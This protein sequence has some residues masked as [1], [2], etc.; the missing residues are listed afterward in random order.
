MNVNKS[1]YYLPFFFFLLPVF[2]WSQK[3]YTPASNRK[4]AAANERICNISFE[5]INLSD[6]KKLDDEVMDYLYQNIKNLQHPS[7]SI[8]QIH[9][10]ESPAGLH[11]TYTQLINDVAVYNSQIKVNLDKQA[12]I[13]SLFDNSYPVS[14][15][16]ATL[17]Y[18]DS[19]AVLKYITNNFDS[20]VRCKFE[21]NLFNDNEQFI[22][23]VRLESFQPNTYNYY[24]TLLDTHGNVLY[25]KDLNS[26]YSP[27]DSL[28][29]AKVFRPDPIT[30]AQVTYGNP[31]GFKDYNDSDVVELNKQRIKVNLTVNFSNGV[32]YLISPFVMVTELS[33]P[34]TAPAITTVPNFDFTRG[35][36]QFEEV[37]AY[38]HLN[39][40]R[41][42]VKSLGFTNL[43]NYQIQVDAHAL[44]GAENSMFSPSSNPPSLL[45]GDG[46]VDDA[47]DADVIVHE[48]GHA[49][50]H[51]AAPNTNSGTERESLDEGLGDYFA[52]SYSRYQSY[53]RWADVFSWDGHNEYW[54]GRST[55][56]T[57]HYPEDLSSDK[58]SNAEMWSSTLMQIW[59]DIGR[60]A[61]DKLL[62]Q[63]LYSYAQNMTMPQAATLFI[64]A[65]SALNGGANYAAICRRFYDRGFI[66]SC[67]VG[68]KEFSNV[69]KN[70]QLLNTREFAD[71][72]GNLTI[73]FKENSRAKIS[74]YSV[75]GKKLFDENYLSAKQIQISGLGFP[76]NV[77]ILQIKTDKELMNTKLVKF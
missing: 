37:N 46:G 52:A 20:T 5:K 61:T 64:Q 17:I 53:Y 14:N 26:Y 11:L 25:Q 54:S 77:Y 76:A 74:I 7:T 10:I 49:L 35:Q 12:N 42:Y 70:I 73:Q 69:S 55:A 51:A 27:Q 63:S 56:S 75:E 19:L 57:K 62:L 18:P 36:K 4:Y 47:E 8:K 22:P 32:F 29:T 65:D 15:N 71:G 34:V 50:S 9:R 31:I 6:T 21:K 68:I 66:I 44:N 40:F 16:P 43:V 2:C 23:V 3:Q 67:L 45:Y 1:T 48:N 28:V 59:N 24:E 30:T 72:S 60:E 39:Y 41:Q 33:A 58:Y 13:T 38:Y